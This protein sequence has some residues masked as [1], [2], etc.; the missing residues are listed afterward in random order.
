[1]KN[2][3]ETHSTANGNLFCF[4]HETNSAWFASKNG[5]P[6]RICENAKEELRF[7]RSWKQ[8]KL[9][10][11]EPFGIICDAKRKDAERSIDQPHFFTGIFKGVHGYF[12]TACG[13][14]YNAHAGESRGSRDKTYLLVLFS[15]ESKGRYYDPTNG[16]WKA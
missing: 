6:L 2:L 13:S 4:D 1:M 5:R 14:A 7:A 16:G 12:V 10:E 3:I 11:K 9:A 15:G 8:D